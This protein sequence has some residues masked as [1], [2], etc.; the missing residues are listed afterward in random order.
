MHPV[1]VIE[2]LENRLAA[3]VSCGAQHTIGLEPEIIGGKVIDG[4]IYKQDFLLHNL[5]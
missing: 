5:I 1:E 2:E 4:R 3:Q